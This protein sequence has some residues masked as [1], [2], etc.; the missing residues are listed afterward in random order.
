MSLE[1]LTMKKIVF[2]L[3][4]LLLSHSPFSEAGVNVG[5]SVTD[6]SSSFFLG[7][8]NYFHV[9]QREVIYVRDRHIPDDQIPVVFFLSQRL[10]VSPSRIIDLRLSGKS[11]LDISVHF[12]LGPDIFYYPIR[13]TVVLHPPYGKAYGYYKNKPKKDWKHIRLQDDDVINLVNLRF[14]SEHYKYDPEHVIKMRE[15]EKHFYR[16][17]DSIEKE[18]KEFRREKEHDGKDKSRTE[19]EK[20]AHKEPG[21]GGKKK[22]SD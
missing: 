4:L 9:P 3:L 6:D 18:K 13:E 5:V 10:S 8:G 20:K 17:T 12:G 22:H 15:R 16:I 11:W 14:I 19:K 1:V 21:K 2:A 7:I